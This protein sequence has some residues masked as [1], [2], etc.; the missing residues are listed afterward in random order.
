MVARWHLARAASSYISIVR[1][2]SSGT[3]SIHGNGFKFLKKVESR[4]S[5][6]EIVFKSLARFSTRFW[7][8]ESFNLYLL[9]KFK[10]FG[11]KS[12]NGV[13]TETT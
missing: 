1:L 11:D 5:Q 10:S 4:R 8:T 7:S 9:N 2:T 6:F 13:A 12:R 3:D